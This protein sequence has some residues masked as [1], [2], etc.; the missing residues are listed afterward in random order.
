MFALKVLRVR[1]LVKTILSGEAVN[2]QTENYYEGAQS[3]P[4]RRAL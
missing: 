3:R 4:R 2:R 1:L